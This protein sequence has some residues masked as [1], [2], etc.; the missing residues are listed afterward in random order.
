MLVHGYLEQKKPT[1]GEGRGV[2]LENKSPCTND[3]LQK[4]MRKEK[5]NIP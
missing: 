5:N 4:R 3:N 2:P 1:Q